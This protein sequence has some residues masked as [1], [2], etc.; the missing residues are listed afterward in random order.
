MLLYVY[1]TLCGNKAFV[2]SSSTISYIKKH[3]SIK[4]DMYANTEEDVFIIKATKR[5]MHV[6]GQRK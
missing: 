3:T 1:S 4:Y 6:K 2:L 5:H